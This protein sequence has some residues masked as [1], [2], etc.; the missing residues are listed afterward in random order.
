MGLHHR[1]AKYRNKAMQEGGPTSIS[2]ETFC[3]KFENTT[4]RYGIIIWHSI[5]TSQ[6]R[7]VV[8]QPEETVC[9]KFENTTVNSK[10]WSHHL[11]KYRNMRMHNQGGGPTLISDE[12]CLQ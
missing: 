8:Q 9:N 12:T 3:N 11:A 10:V 2:D 7:K 6:Y 5:E 4:V 1:L